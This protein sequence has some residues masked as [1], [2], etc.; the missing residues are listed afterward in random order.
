MDSDPE[1][2][3]D[4]LEIWNRERGD[5]SFKSFRESAIALP[6]NGRIFDPFDHIRKCKKFEVYMQNR[7]PIVQTNQ[8]SWLANMLTRESSQERAE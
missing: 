5:T 8:Q 4:P 6:Q 3:L 1:S 2:I 7:C